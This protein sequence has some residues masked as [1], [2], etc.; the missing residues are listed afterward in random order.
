MLMNGFLPSHD[1][2]HYPTPYYHVQESP[3]LLWFTLPDADEDP[4]FYVGIYGAI[5]LATAAIGI[6]STAVQHTGGLR[7][8]RLIFKQLWE[9]VVRA[10][11]RW[12]DVTPQGER[13]VVDIVDQLM[14][15]EI[16]RMLNRF[17]KDIETIGNNLAS[18]LSA[19]NLSLATFAAAIITAAYVVVSILG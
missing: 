15:D 11:M 16:G 8:L 10:T 3:K 17:G 18:S 19:V 5:G 7:V 1:M 2:A 6:A 13:D 9:G 14:K 12:Y 4:L